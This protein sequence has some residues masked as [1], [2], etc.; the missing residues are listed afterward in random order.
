MDALKGNEIAEFKRR[1]FDGKCAYLFGKVE[2][3]FSG[4]DVSV[5]FSY[6]KLCQVTGIWMLVCSDP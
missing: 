5:V 1:L 4:A 2:G 3:G 6:G